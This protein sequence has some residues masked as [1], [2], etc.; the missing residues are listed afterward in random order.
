MAG[1]T[2][3]APERTFERGRGCWNCVAGDTL[4]LTPSGPYRIEA[5]AAIDRTYSRDGWS[6]VANWVSSGVKEVLE[7]ETTYG[8]KIRMTPD[9]RIFTERGW[10]CAAD[11]RTG[12]FQSPK[13]P[14]VRS[15]SWK[16]GDEVAGLGELTLTYVDTI[17]RDQA[18]F[19]GAIIGNGWLEPKKGIGFGFAGDMRDWS[20]VYRFAQVGLDSYEKPRERRDKPGFYQTEWRTEAA[21]KF[22][23]TFNKDH[24][25]TPIWQA[26]P[27]VIGAFVRGLFSTDGTFSNHEAIFYQTN[28]NLV[29][30]LQLLLR[31]IGIASHVR[32]STRTRVDLPNGK[33]IENPKGLYS[34]G[35]RRVAALKRFRDL[36][37]FSDVERQD[38]LTEFVRNTKGRNSPERITS[39][40]PAGVVTVYDISVPANESFY[41]NSVLVHN[42][43]AYENGAL[44]RQH[45][46]THQI[47]LLAALQGSAPLHRLGD[48]ED[49]N[50]KP[51]V[52]RERDARRKQIDQMDKAVTNGVIG[53]CMKGSRPEADGGPEGDFVEHRFLCDRWNGKQGSSVATSGQP[54]D[55]LNDELYDI[56]EDR[57]KRK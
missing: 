6:N 22:A 29:D 56:A 53:M 4:I 55:K 39:V 12:S 42:C 45:W 25:P 31:T 16:P 13:R 57:A 51:G 15:P 19:Y 5:A 21:R 54:L 47:R 10:M 43:T 3:S 2:F 26:S 52:D 7:V 9:H 1:K 38:Q 23:T 48:M 18:E 34:L 40:K 17:S 41:G 50:W 27:S 24:I 46:A 44:S 30:E 14:W 8:A 35:I 28:Q 32:L 33:V 36:A 20:A 37:G 49:P 11:L